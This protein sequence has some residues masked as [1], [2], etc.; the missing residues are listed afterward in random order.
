MVPIQ[1]LYV[2]THLNYLSPGNPMDMAYGLKA[3]GLK[4][5]TPIS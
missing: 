1:D 3:T 4:S 2:A 5:E